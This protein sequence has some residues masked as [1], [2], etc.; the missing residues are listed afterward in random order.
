MSAINE[1]IVREYFELHGFLLRQQR[2]SFSPNRR[3]DEDVDFVVV[4]PSPQT[5][6]TP[7]PF[8]LSSE[9]LAGLHYGIVVVKGWHTEIF[10]PAM[11]AQSPEKFRFL[12]P[13]ILRQK[14]SQ[15][16]RAAAVTKILVVPALPQ[17]A[18]VREQSIAVLREKG[19]DAVLQFRTI[20][21]DLVNKTEPSRNYQQSD[22]LQIIRLLKKYDFIKGPQLE[23]F[24]A[25]RK[26]RK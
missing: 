1:A 25:V 26:K 12:E 21:A 14:D 18:E 9:N 17:L 5:V 10:S 7:L 22:V 16:G 8:V 20:L 3:D 2:K 23:L 4:N 13:D 6:E 11:L 15:L 19:I 24:K